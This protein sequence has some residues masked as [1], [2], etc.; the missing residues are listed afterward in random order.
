MTDGRYEARERPVRLQGRPWSRSG[1]LYCFADLTLDTG[2][3]R[4]SRAGEPIS[5]GRLSY[6]ML[7]VLAESAPN[8]VSREEFAAKV[9]KGRLV[10]PET[11]TQRVKLLR[12]ALCDRADRPRYIGLVRGHGY[13]LIQEVRTT[14]T[15]WP[16]E[17]R[18][19]VLPFET[20]GRGQSDAHFADGLHEEVLT[21]MARLK[22]IQVMARTS[23]IQYAK[24]RRSIHEIAEELGV[25]YVMEGSVRYAADR[26]RITAQLV[27]GDT[28][29]HT[30]AEAY[31]RKLDHAFDIQ[32]EIAMRIS[33]SLRSDVFTD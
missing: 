32:T 12:D 29:A 23:V 13:R 33:S 1:S 24:N 16:R 19:A 11:V 9:W 10:S 17:R 22:T 28:G 14:A 3:C 6:R 20:L 7:L 2:Q 18:V 25:G 21:Q 27:N 8:V 4:V 31:E 30:W 15:G 26:A 5:L